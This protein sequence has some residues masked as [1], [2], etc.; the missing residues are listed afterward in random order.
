MPFLFPVL[1]NP[2]DLTE[3]PILLDR[4]SCAL[5]R[6]QRAACRLPVP[7]VGILRSVFLE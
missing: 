5:D 7:D 3:N 2:T 6:A 1:P 4:E